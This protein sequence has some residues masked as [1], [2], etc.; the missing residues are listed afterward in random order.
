MVWKRSTERRSRS[1]RAFRSCGGGCLPR[2]GLVHPYIP[3][4]ANHLGISS[5]KYPPYKR[6]GSMSEID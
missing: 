2:R 4:G 5:T 1:R 6:T 3:T